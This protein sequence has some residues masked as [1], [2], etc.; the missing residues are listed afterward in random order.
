MKVQQIERP[1]SYEIRD[2]ISKYDDSIS[3]SVGEPDYQTPS[4]IIEEG[5]KALN[6]GF[7]HYAGDTGLLALRETISKTL[8]AEK[9]LDFDPISGVVI[10]VGSAAANFAAIMSLIDPG[11]EVILPSIYY[12]PY[13]TATRLAG[14]IPKLMKLREDR[15][16]NP[17]PED[18]DSVITERTKLFIVNSPNNPTGGVLERD[19]L[20]HIADVSKKHDLFILSDEV[21]EKFVYDGMKVKSI[22]TFPRMFERTI[23]TNSFSKTY[24]MTGWRVGYAAGDPQLISQLLKVH[25]AMNVSAPMMAQKAAITA[26]TGSQDPVIEM[27]NE[28]DRRRKIM[29]EGLN[30][31][32]GITCALPKGAFYAF[33]NISSFGISSIAL[34][35][36]LA[37]EAR[38]AT[39][40]GIAFGPDGEGHLRLSYASSTKSIIEAIERVDVFLEQMDRG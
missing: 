12:P 29:F 10:T 23:I 37:M 22:A 31:I 27:V 20:E 40:P 24:A 6:Q 28:Y 25:Y 17:A 34:A 1:L 36:R 19:I 21:Y 7:T 3:L 14:G 5:T 4:H 32:R 33:P 16:F 18:V 9:G 38:V 11:D 15:S 2:L 39:V 13:L 30:K 35:K 26:L 8:K